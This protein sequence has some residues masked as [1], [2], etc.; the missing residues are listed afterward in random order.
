MQA[1]QIRQAFKDYFSSQGHEIASPLSVVPWQDDTLLFTNA[2]MVNFKDCFMG[3]QSPPS[4]RVA[5]IQP[6]IRAGGKHNDLDEVGYTTRHHTF[7]E[8]L[9]NFS[10]GDY[11]KEE[12]ILFAWDFIT[13]QMKIDKDKLFVTVHQKDV[14]SHQLWK[15]VA[16]LEDGRIVQIESDDN[17][18]SMGEVGPCGYCTEIFFDYGKDFAGKITQSGVEGARFVELWNL[19]FM[20]YEMREDGTSHELA[21]HGVD[22]GMGLERLATLMQGEHDNYKSDELARLVGHI[23]EAAQGWKGT[24]SPFKSD[25]AVAVKV[26]ADHLRSSVALMA[27]GIEPSNEGRGYVLRRILRRAMRYGYGLGA[28]E[29]CLYQFVPFVCSLMDTTLEQERGLEV[30]KKLLKDEEERFG[31][32][33]ARGLF[34][35][36]EHQQKLKKGAQ[37]SGEVAFLLYDTYGFPLDMTKDVLRAQGVGIDEVGYAKAMKEQSSRAR[38]AHKMRT[39]NVNENAT[40]WRNE[41]QKSEFIGYEAR[42]CAGRIEGMVK[43]GALVKKATKG[44]EVAFVLDKTSLYAEQ[45]GQ[46]SDYGELVNKKGEIVA[47]IKDVQKMGEGVFVHWGEAVSAV[48]RGDEVLARYDGQRRNA[49]CRHHTAT[50]LLHE[51]LRR[52]LGSHVAQRGSLVAPHR[53]RFD[54]SHGDTLTEDDIFI[55]E[56]AVNARI[57][58]DDEVITHLMSLDDAKARGARALFGERYES[59]VRVVGMGEDKEGYDGFYSL[60]LCGGTHVRRTGELG[61]FKIVAQSGVAAGV[62]RLEGMVAQDAVLYQRMKINAMTQ[63]MKNLQKELTHLKKN[64]EKASLGQQSFVDENIGSRLLRF[65][66]MENVAMPQLRRLADKAL[67]DM[68]TGMVLLGSQNESNGLFVLAI[69]DMS[70][71]ASRILNEVLVAKGGKAGGRKNFAQGGAQGMIDKEQLLAQCRHLMKNHE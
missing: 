53:L 5:T 42:E 48:G 70:L 37:L 69:K 22:T 2:G 51:A 12:A 35:L 6:C 68:K 39:W 62:R 45:G 34:V 7:F 10:F 67:M 71:D 36:R 38:T 58:A 16:S 1:Q 54:F 32:T 14:Q 3:L 4:P 21:H 44:D 27:A 29:A 15:K 31:A 23:R 61:F 60:E 40:L 26:I 65:S 9:G 24:D 8:M 49:L 59:E 64:M 30:I 13:Q 56:D 41:F 20:Q 28:D 17:F 46:Q 57:F 47:H 33:L 50:H 63:E 43:D 18:W 55:V 25:E 19:V 66:F 52:H 11:F